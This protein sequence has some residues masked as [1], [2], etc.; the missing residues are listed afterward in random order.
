MSNNNIFKIILQRIYVENKIENLLA[1]LGC[2][3]ISYEQ[4]G[5]L[6]TASLP[7]GDN[8][9]SVQIKNNEHLN[10]R[11]WS[12]GIENTNLYGVIGYI[13][14][15]STTF[16][17]NKK[18]ISEIK[19][20]ICSQFNWHEYE[21]VII[22][23]EV[24]DPL[25]WLREI[26]KERLK[27]TCTKENKVL[28]GWVM[29]QYIHY[30]IKAWYDEGI[31]CITQEEFQVAFDID[32]ERI[33]FPV[34][35][36]H[37]QIVS[38]KGRYIGDSQEILNSTKYI[39]LYKFDKSLELFNLWRADDYIKQKKQ[40]IVLEGEKTV[41]K[42]WGLGCRNCVAIGGSVL[43]SYQID[44]LKEYGLDCEIILAWDKDKDE[45][46][47]AKEIKKFHTIKVRNIS[48]MYDNKGLLSAGDKD[49]PIDKGEEIFKKLYKQRYKVKI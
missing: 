36:K 22:K 21:G 49:S 30:P 20:W 24:N 39:Y 18:H 4:N 47:I 38:V 37:G 32:T 8:K 27:K 5:Q 11:I 16:D 35:N 31:S 15:N 29:S 9:R 2:K 28:P 45:N 19:D 3:N 14:Y 26:K 48:V 13:Q 43:S 41:M 44:A 23:E 25:L 10:A 34:H 1:K 46:F 6:I 12:R 7:D 17:E 40:V 42:L 33:V